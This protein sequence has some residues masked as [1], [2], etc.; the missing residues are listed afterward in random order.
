MRS[1]TFFGDRD[2]TWPS[3]VV[4]LA[5]VAATLVGCSTSPETAPSAAPP[6]DTG[7]EETPPPDNGVG[8]VSNANCSGGKIC[9][10][11]SCQSV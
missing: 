5:L 2:R 10:S 7:G 3:T 1:E 4:L 6:D 9:A 8:C 11:G